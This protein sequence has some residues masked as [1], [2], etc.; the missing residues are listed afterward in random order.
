VGETIEISLTD[1]KE[2][3]QNQEMDTTMSSAQENNAE[4]TAASGEDV[5]QQN[6]QASSVNIKQIRKPLK[7]RLVVLFLLTALVPLAIIGYVAS[8]SSQKAL[9][10]QYLSKLE[11]TTEA[12][13]MAV[14]LYLGGLVNFGVDGYVS[15]EMQ[16][17][18]DTPEQASEIKKDL[19]DYL[20]EN[21]ISSHFHAHEVYILNPKGRVILSSI[22][23]IVGKDESRHLRSLFRTGCFLLI[24]RS[25]N[26][27]G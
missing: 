6:A 12:R 7:W 15:T 8:S 3:N 2:D 18:K 27:I 20:K 21:Q 9:E 26:F 25:Q 24:G 1:L 16:M 4:M 14:T 10:E 19:L 11:A 22:P 17:L 5:A 23:A 13:E